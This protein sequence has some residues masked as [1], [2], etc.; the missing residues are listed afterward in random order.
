MA[1]KPLDDHFY[2]QVTWRKSF[3]WW[4]PCTFV[5]F[6]CWICVVLLL[7]WWQPLQVGDKWWW[8]GDILSYSN[9]ILHVSFRLLLRLYMYSFDVIHLILCWCLVALSICT[10]FPLLPEL[11]P[12]LTGSLASTASTSVAMGFSYPQLRWGLINFTHVLTFTLTNISSLSLSFSH[13]LSLTV[14]SSSQSR[15]WLHNF[16]LVLTFTF[17]NS[18]FVSLGDFSFLLLLIMALSI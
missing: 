16:T 15:R 10:G 14:A 18:S 11:F 12:R 7:C 5:A 4:V 8:Q 3:A 13:S 17:S 2:L 9:L 6:K 1:W